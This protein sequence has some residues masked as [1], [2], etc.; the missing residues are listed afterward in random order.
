MADL[1]PHT[2]PSA[3]GHIVSAW[4]AIF[5]IHNRALRISRS[6]HHGI[7]NASA[8]DCVNVWHG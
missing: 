2:G 8:T 1:Q 3:S 5:Q 7:A 4:Q 6:M